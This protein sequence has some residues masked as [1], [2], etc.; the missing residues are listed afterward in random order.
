MTPKHAIPILLAFTTAGGVALGTSAIAVAETCP[1]SGA[2]EQGRPAL[3]AALTASLGVS[4]PK[5]TRA[6]CATRRVDRAEV[7]PSSVRCREADQGSLAACQGADG[8][9]T[10][11]SQAPRC[12]TDGTTASDGE[13]VPARRLADEAGQADPVEDSSVRDGTLPQGDFG[14]PMPAEWPGAPGG[15]ASQE[16]PDG[17][18][19]IA[20]IVVPVNASVVVPR[21]PGGGAPR[22]VDRPG[23]AGGGVPGTTGGGAPGGTAPGQAGRPGGANAPTGPVNPQDRATGDDAPKPEA[24]EPREENT[25]S[26]PPARDAWP[27]RVSPQAPEP[28]DAIGSLPFTGAPAGIAAAGAGLL[29]VGIGATVVRV[30]RRRRSPGVN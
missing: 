12:G 29:A 13:D 2:V 15:G 19:P 16:G 7:C 23:T 10:R 20:P 11:V 17:A 26:A 6:D 18:M 24:K 4:I 1:S 5:L 25:P 14:Q 28:V 27:G 3:S 22:V 21:L 9:A 30:R 8:D